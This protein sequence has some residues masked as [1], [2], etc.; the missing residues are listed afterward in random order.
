MIT[1]YPYFQHVIEEFRHMGGGQSG[2]LQGIIA[3]MVKIPPEPYLRSMTGSMPNYHKLT[4]ND[5]TKDVQYHIA[6]YGIYNEEAIIRF[7]GESV[8]RYA[9]IVTES[10]WRSVEWISASASLI[11]CV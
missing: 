6:G 3:P 7:M 8:E 4:F 10:L 9:P 5:P 1:Y 11:F 2:I